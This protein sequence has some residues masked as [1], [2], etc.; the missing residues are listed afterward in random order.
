MESLYKTAGISRQAH[1]KKKVLEEHRLKQEQA[2]ISQVRQARL[3]H[4]RMGSRPLYHLLEVKTMG[5]NRFEGLIKKE[6]LGIKRKKNYHKTTDGYKFKGKSI[7]LLNNKTLYGINQAWVTDITYFIVGTKVFY[8]II[9][10]DV[11]SR[12][13]LGCEVFTNM[14]AENNLLV[15]KKALK[16]RN[17]KHYR[18][19]LIH[20]SDKGSQYMSNEYKLMLE[21]Y[22][23]QLSVAE[24]SLQNAY[25][26]RI[27]G[28]IKH[29]YLDY[30]ATENL[31]I[32]RKYLR[33]CVDLYNNE[34]PH[35]SLK[36]LTPEAFEESLENGCGRPI[37]LYDFSQKVVYA[38]FEAFDK[39]NDVNK[40][41]GFLKTVISNKPIP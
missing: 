13:I 28:T 15:L 2:L 41:T 5:I 25:A 21:K 31:P 35:S 23:I 39:Q 1:Y 27:N 16:H 40:E 24:N 26:E 4:P 38:F 9:I 7:N 6:G 17:I 20:H 36:Y 12:K 11:Y 37:Q 34:R 10:M 32:L 19:E 30:H 33:Y 29:D 22:G 8:I 18:G 3:S 14:F